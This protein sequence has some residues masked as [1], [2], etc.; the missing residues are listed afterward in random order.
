MIRLL[1]LRLL[2]PPAS[3]VGA[4]WLEPGQR[5]GGGQA[6]EGR[7]VEGRLLE[8]RL[9]EGRLLEGRLAVGYG[10]RRYM[11]WLHLPWR[12]LPWPHY[13]PRLC[14]TAM[15]ATATH[16]TAM[17]LTAA[18]LGLGLGLILSLTLSLSLSLSLTLILTLTWVDDDGLRGD[19]QEEH[20]K[21]LEHDLYAEEG[22][23]EERGEGLVRLALLHAH[24]RR[25][26][27][28]AVREVL[29]G[30]VQVGGTRVG[31]RCGCECG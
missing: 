8:G 7:L 23:G 12:R 3:V 5:G 2:S 11:A 19:G 24:L 13:Y 1:T 6:D 27:L 17:L 14:L 9:L 10:T 20:G 28:R 29:V 15:L 16:A 25:V 18:W 21:E 4:E 22:E 26:Q 31:R 30:V